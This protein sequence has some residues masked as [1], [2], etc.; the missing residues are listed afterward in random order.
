[1]AMHVNDRESC[2]VTVGNMSDTFIKVWN[3]RG[4]KL[5]EVNTSQVEHYQANF[6]ENYLMLRSWNT[7][8]KI[9]HIVYA[10]DSKEFSK[11]EKGA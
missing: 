2:I 4:E 1:M 5:A 8:L 6:G 9:Y 7:E 3:L 10:K 11:I